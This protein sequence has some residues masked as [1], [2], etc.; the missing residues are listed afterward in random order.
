LSKRIV[1]QAFKFC[2]DNKLRLTEP[3]IE[4]LKIISRNGK[5][6]KA[7]EVLDKLSNT[8]KNPKPPTA[9]RAIEFWKKYNFIHRIESLN[10]YLLCEANHFHNGT[11]FL[12]CDSCGK[13]IESH[14][15]ELPEALKNS[16]EKNT[17]IP[18]TWHLEINGICHQCK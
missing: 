9:Y 6:I 1:E 17:F 3:R 8:I 4:V 14:L 13:V 18:S 11:Q 12:I 15:C 2:S 5:P 7:Y 16:T 10:A